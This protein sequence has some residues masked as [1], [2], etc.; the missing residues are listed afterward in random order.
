MPLFLHIKLNFEWHVSTIRPYQTLKHNN[1]IDINNDYDDDNL[2]NYHDDD[3]NTNDDD[4]DDDDNDTDADGGV[5]HRPQHVP[6]CPPD[7]VV[8]VSAVWPVSPRPEDQTEVTGGPQRQTGRQ[9]VSQIAVLGK[10]SK[11]PPQ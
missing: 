9:S 3:N 5:Q 10:G 11:I 1:F 6:V 4:D 7:G 8:P 2:N